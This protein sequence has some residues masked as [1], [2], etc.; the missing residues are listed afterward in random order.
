MR[1]RA[2]WHHICVYTVLM[3]FHQ[4]PISHKLVNL[5][6]GSL[7]GTWTTCKSRLVVLMDLVPHYSSN[8][9]L[10]SQSQIM[11]ELLMLGRKTPILL[12]IR[13]FRIA[14]SVLPL[15]YQNKNS[16]SLFWRTLK[17][18]VSH[19]HSSTVLVLSKWVLIREK[20]RDS[21]TR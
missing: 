3:R 7:T 21:H 4:W 15:Y 11:T 8:K 9:I 16:I 10:E 13:L 14:Y 18:Q 2:L 5:K 6:S 17:T 20:E 19:T 1:C 12:H